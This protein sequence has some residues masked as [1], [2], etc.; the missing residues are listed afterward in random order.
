MRKKKTKLLILEAK[1]IKEVK[2]IMT[3]TCFLGTSI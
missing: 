1:K 2:K 3:G